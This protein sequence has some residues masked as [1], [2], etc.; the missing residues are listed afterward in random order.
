MP[1]TITTLLAWAAGRLTGATARLDAEILL[2]HTLQRPRSHLRAR[3]EAG[4]P[5]DVAA[6]FR[7]LIERRAAGSAVAHLTGTRE[8]WS[9]PLAVTTD[10]LIPR[11]ETELLVEQALLRIPADA[12]WDILDLG[13]G[14]GAIALAIASE[15]PACRVT[16]TDVSIAA[17]A[18]ARRNAERLAL[19]NVAFLAGDWFAPVAGRRFHLLASNPP[20]IAEHDPH[21]RQGDVRFEPRGALAAGADGLDCIRTLAAEAPGH[22]FDNGWLLL[23]HGHDQGAAVRRLLAGHGYRD[24]ATQRDLAGHERIT[25][26]RVADER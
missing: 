20:Y 18:V 8:F 3:P 2:A 6:R 11:P 7:A 4:V 12:S 14:S 10:T 1:D 24:I 15:R 16:A 21:L 23:E 19:G 5:A 9:L 22:L 13:T 17:L 26:A 25:L